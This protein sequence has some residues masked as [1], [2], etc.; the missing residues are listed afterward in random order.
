VLPFAGAMDPT[1]IRRFQTEA[2]A[3]A[4]LHHTNIVPV[5]SVGCER[6]VHYYAMQFIESHTLEAAIA[7]RRELAAPK[8]GE[9]SSRDRAY[10]RTIANLGIQAAEALDHA[11]K[12]GIIHRDI[13]PANLLLDEAGNLWITDFGLARF[14]EDSGLTMTGDALG[15][16]RYMSPE[17]ALAKRGYLDHRTDIYSLGATLYE[18]WT[19]R[20]AIEGS[21]RQELLRSIAQDEP[22]S[23]RKHNPAIPRELETILLKAMS[24]EAGDRYATAQ[25]LADDLLGF[26]EDKPIK[27]KRPTP[28]ERAAKWAKR[29]RTLVSAAA[30]LLVLVAL[31]LAVST[32]LI[33]HEQSRTRHALDA[34]QEQ[35]RLAEVQTAEVRA[36][37]VRAEANFDKALGVLAEWLIDTSDRENPSR[38]HQLTDKQR[39]LAGEVIR[40][41]RGLLEQIHR[42]PATRLEPLEEGALYGYMAMVHSVLGDVSGMGEAYGKSLE[43]HHIAAEAD[44]DDWSGWWQLGQI[45][46]HFGRGLD[47][48]G[49]PCEAAEQFRHAEECFVRAARLAP[50]I[51][52]PL[53]YLSRLLATCPRTQ[54]RNPVR[55]VE[56]A[57]RATS[58]EPRTAPAW[59]ALGM[60][61]CAAGHDDE[62][63]A[64]LERSI[65]LRSGGSGYDWFFL[66]I[67][68]ARRGDR[69][70]ARGWYVKAVAWMEGLSPLDSELRR[71]RDEAA[72]L[73]GQAESTKH[74]TRGV[75]TPKP[76]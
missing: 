21:D 61:H 4:Q 22:V 17:Q 6:G 52:T 40:F 70:Q 45:H 29:H 19:L 5:Y 66:A 10:I 41:Y 23:A 50:R 35:R 9:D 2:L 53:H 33:S 11:H 12:V 74:E 75:A 30:I 42:D 58:L 47:D 63:I 59:R 44:T 72:A 1:Q 32:V 62:A 20:P 13:K 46:G 38:R 18:L 51:A 68:H 69:D 31:M 24:K 43:F 36:Q 57:E 56:L 7:E 55:A 14:Q 39:W 64:A 27:A 37:R 54:I 73:L 76:D 34:A 25:E 15:T 60:A 3:A 49:R 26:L 48:L 8:A 16:L 71:F 28:M 65:E 67:A